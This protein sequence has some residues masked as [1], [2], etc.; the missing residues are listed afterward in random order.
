MCLQAEAE[1]EILGNL[2]KKINRKL[3][4]TIYK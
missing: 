2:N 3:H 4:V 1:S